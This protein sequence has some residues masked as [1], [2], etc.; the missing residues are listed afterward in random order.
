[1][2]FKDRKG[3]YNTIKKWTANR[4][5]N[6]RYRNRQC[7]MQYSEEKINNHEFNIPCFSWCQ[8]RLDSRVYCIPSHVF[9]KET[10][11]LN[12]L[13]IPLP[14]N[15]SNDKPYSSFFV[16]LS[17]AYSIHDPSKTA[18]LP[19]II[20]LAPTYPAAVPANALQTT[21]HTPTI[22]NRSYASPLRPAAHLKIIFSGSPMI[23]PCF[24]KMARSSVGLRIM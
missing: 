18:Q 1:M 13:P 22:H 16:S 14:T 17:S 19:S 8:Q 6:A 23:T 2:D 24:S 12:Q 15:T 5:R 4:H 3:K 11:L 21:P 20:S 9:N 7:V 10:V